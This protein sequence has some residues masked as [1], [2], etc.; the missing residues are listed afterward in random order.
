MA[1]DSLSVGG[2][3]VSLSALVVPGVSSCAR[4]KTGREASVAAVKS[5]KILRFIF[6]T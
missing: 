4:L 6:I 2:A 1:I 5:V 3:L